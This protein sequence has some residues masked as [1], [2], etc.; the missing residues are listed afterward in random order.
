MFLIINFLKNKFVDLWRRGAF[1]ILLGSFVTKFVVF[2]GTIFLVRILSKTSYGVLG[3]IENI[4]G[5]IYIFAG[6]GLNNAVLRYVILGKTSEEKFG[7]Y[8]YAITKGTLFNILI[9]FFVALFFLFYP[10]P[11]EFKGAKWLLLILFITIPFQF[12]VDSNTLTYRAM[13]DNKRFAIITFLT[14][15]ILIIARYLGAIFF[16][17]N[18]IVIANILV[19][20]LFS[21]ILSYVSFNLYFKEYRPNQLSKI[22]QKKVNNY[23]FQYMITN[24]VWAA[25]MLNDV[26]LLGLLSGNAEIV[27]EYKV[28][29]VLPGVL[30]IISTAIGIFIGPYFVKR[31][32]NHNW[33]WK[34]YIKTL[35][36]LAG[37]IA[38]LV[39]IMFVYAKSITTLI[40]GVQYE[41]IVPIMRLLL[42]AA[43]IN[44]IFRYTSANL[45]ASMGEIK[46]NMLISIFGMCLQIIINLILIP[47]YGE[48]GAAVTS[49]L[50]YS[51][52]A[53][54]LFIIF[55]KKFKLTN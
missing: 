18:G 34:N 35:I 30:T 44:S 20:V 37:I 42:V 29:Y 49:I 40:Y 50:V 45:L 31:E 27:A 41:N 28:A 22:E 8:R 54:S 14:S 33:V 38:P 21:L 32:T 23:S 55:I 48:L 25:F 15:V 16:D 12:L 24:G 9:V 13:F 7:F 39:A 4:Y 43:L 5:Y 47:K 36:I 46:S 51:L 53:L 3:Y 11:E 10:Y 19:Y 52:M 17:L 6:L 2:F 1:H 26:F